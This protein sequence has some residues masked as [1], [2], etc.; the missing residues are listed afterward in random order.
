MERRASNCGYFRELPATSGPGT[1]STM[2]DLGQAESKKNKLEP[3]L[4]QLADGGIGSALT[5]QTNYGRGGGNYQLTRQPCGPGVGVICWVWGDT[6]G[7]QRAGMIVRVVMDASYCDGEG[8][9]LGSG[10]TE[11]I[12]VGKISTYIFTSDGWWRRSGW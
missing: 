5:M 6:N 4:N 8:R 1:S 11:S 10:P 9:V 2:A 3:K 7:L 12:Q